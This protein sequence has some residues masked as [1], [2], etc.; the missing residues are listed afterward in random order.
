MLGHAATHSPPLISSHLV[1]LPNSRHSFSLRPHWMIQLRIRKVA[2]GA[3]PHL[4]SPRNHH[5]ISDFRILAGRLLAQSTSLD[6]RMPHG[7]QDV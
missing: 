1:T 4:L 2:R 3:P 6:G 7:A 5:S